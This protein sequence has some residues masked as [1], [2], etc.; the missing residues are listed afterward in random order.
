MSTR[1]S[2]SAKFDSI[3][4]RWHYDGVIQ[5]GRF[6]ATVSFEAEQPDEDGRV[7]DREHL[8]DISQ[9]VYDLFY[10]NLIVSQKDPKLESVTEAH[11]EHRVTGGVSSECFAQLVHGEIE[12]MLTDDPAMQY[13]NML[14]TRYP[15]VHCR[16]VEL[17]GI[18]TGIVAV[19]EV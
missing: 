6:D 14:G 13:E 2:I 16:R 8:K 19:S 10:T 18:E 3:P 9:H 1:I 12:Q 5:E 4:C 17:S 7:F 11:P 15:R